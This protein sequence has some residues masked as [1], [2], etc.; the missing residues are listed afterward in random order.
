MHR[1][2]H[3]HVHT[4]THTRTLTTPTHT[5]IYVH[6][7]THLLPRTHINTHSN[8]HHSHTLT[9]VHAPTHSPPRTQA[10]KCI[11]DKHLGCSQDVTRYL[12]TACGGRRSC[13][14]RVSDLLPEQVQP[15]PSDYRGYLQVAY[16]CVKG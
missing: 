6:A 5:L 16:E 7:P 4:L 3:S 8:I 2:T 1:H 14:G 13:S 11:S 9:Y 12:D 10:G 15:C